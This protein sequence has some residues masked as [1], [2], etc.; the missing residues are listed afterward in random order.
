MLRLQSRIK[1]GRVR[2]L[3]QDD[4]LL[5]FC[6]QVVRRPRGNGS[7][8]IADVRTQQSGFRS[9]SMHVRSFDSRGMKC[10][11]KYS[12]SQLPFIPV[13][14]DPLIMWAVSNFWQTVWRKI[15]TTERERTKLNPDWCRRMRPS[16]LKGWT[17]EACKGL[18][19][20]M[21]DSQQSKSKYIPGEERSRDFTSHRWRR[22]GVRDNETV[23]DGWSARSAGR[24]LACSALFCLHLLSYFPAHNLYSFEISMQSTR[25]PVVLMC[26]ILLNSHHKCC[27]LFFLNVDVKAQSSCFTHQEVIH[28]LQS[29]ARFASLSPCRGDNISNCLICRR[30]KRQ[31]TG[32][33]CL[34]LQWKLGCP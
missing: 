15:W 14:Q 1:N 17:K 6:C 19:E 22:G 25:H 31:Q 20:T 27:F 30:V 12:N 21:S 28:N 3:T 23:G 32:T 34:R 18:I 9:G 7:C 2:T 11:I 26:Q 8:A 13:D 5:T 10:N 24:N 4:S 16:V 33:I 29:I